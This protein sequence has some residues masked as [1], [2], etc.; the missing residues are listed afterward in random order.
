MSNI[1]ASLNE[2][3]GIEASNA[4]GFWM[5]IKNLIIHCV[6]VMIVLLMAQEENDAKR[7]VMAFLI[8][9]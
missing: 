6:T 7:K 5:K 4:D 8:C 2:A 3:G 9:I 1:I